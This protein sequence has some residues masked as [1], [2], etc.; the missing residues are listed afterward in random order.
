M[1]PR[2]DLEMLNAVPPWEWPNDAGALFIEVLRDTA[3]EESDRLIAAEL[4]GDFTVVN[5]EIFDILLSIIANDEETPSL[6]GTA[7]IALGP[8]LDHSAMEGFDDPDDMPISEPTF[9][10]AQE[11][12]RKLFMDGDVP[13]EVR[14]RILEA[15]VRAPQDWHQE[16]IRDAYSND[17]DDWKL[18]AV[19]SMCYVGGFEEQIL[20]ALQSDNEEIEYEAV[21]S[22]GNWGLDAA[23]RHI[24]GIVTAANPDKVLLL[25]AIEALASIRPDQA[26][27]VLVDLTLHDDEEIVD[28]A[29]EGMAMAETM[30]MLEGS[31][32]DDDEED[33]GW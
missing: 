22:A 7:A 6:R 10:K 14:R 32:D 8:A 11:L 31:L 4:A 33:L 30:A 3:S 18:T 24:E 25:A 13:K 5:D 26:G 15:S 12:L 21:Q 19:F 27:M 23:W 2:M 9:L 1:A 16:A 17:D 28:A 20:E 29:N